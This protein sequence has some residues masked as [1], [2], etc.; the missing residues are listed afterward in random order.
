MKTQIYCKSDVKADEQGVIEGYASVFGGID[1]YADTI[2]DT[3]FDNVIKSAVMPK[4][5]FNHDRWYL[6]IG[7]WEEMEA[8]EKGLR[9]KGRLNLALDEARQV[10]EAVKF[11]SIDGLSIGFTLDD[12][13]FTYDDDGVRHIHNVSSLPEV[14]IVTF[15]ADKSARIENVKA[16][17][18][19]VDSI[20]EF[21]RFLRDAGGFSK[22]EALV[23]C[24]KA[25][26]IF[27]QSSGE[28][29]VPEGPNLEPALAAMRDLMA[30][31]KEANN[32]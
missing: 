9:L 22:N 21:E 17:L 2:E 14:S 4:M 32:G 13:G 12:N 11:G 8:D 20:R 28:Q 24:A 7:K 29:S 27:G 30:K 5:F 26:G 1:S 6:P 15:P 25:R 10:Y 3:A 18:E 31:L 19:E 23:I 16:A